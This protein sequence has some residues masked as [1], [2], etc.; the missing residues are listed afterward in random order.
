MRD[1]VALS[2]TCMMLKKGADS[3]SAT[4]SLVDATEAYSQWMQDRVNP[5]LWA[6]NKAI[7]DVHK[8]ITKVE[9]YFIRE[10]R[11]DSNDESEE[12]YDEY[13]EYPSPYGGW[14]Y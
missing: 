14:G 11:Y 9:R 1:L 2:R 10:Y 12:E 4:T 3:E 13:D 5:E 7:Q 6:S 8:S